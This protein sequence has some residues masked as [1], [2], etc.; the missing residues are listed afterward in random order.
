[1]STGNAKRPIQVPA[2]PG[3]RREFTDGWGGQ[4]RHLHRSL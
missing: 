1:M 3:A 2:L 4:Q